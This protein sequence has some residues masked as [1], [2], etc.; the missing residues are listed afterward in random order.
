[1]ICSYTAEGQGETEADDIR[2]A[3]SRALSSLFPEK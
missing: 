2:Q 1:M 3:I